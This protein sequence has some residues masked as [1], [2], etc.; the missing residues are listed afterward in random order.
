MHVDC[1]IYETVTPGWSENK[2]GKVC[3]KNSAQQRSLCLFIFPSILF[4]WAG[5]TEVSSGR[6]ECEWKSYVTSCSE[7]LRASMLPTLFSCY[8]QFISHMMI[9][10]HDKMEETW[11]VELPNDKERSVKL[12]W[13]TFVKIQ[14]FWSLS[15]VATS[16]NYLN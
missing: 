7:H 14:R 3:K 9:R 13:I 10:G 11:I 2:V 6:W 1:F 8:N 15:V 16:I 5:D 12:C 4:S